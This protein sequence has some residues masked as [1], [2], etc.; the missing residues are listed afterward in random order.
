METFFT[1]TD[2]QSQEITDCAART[3]GWLRGGSPVV[4]CDLCPGNGTRYF[5][6]LTAMENSVPNPEPMVSG[7]YVLSLPFFQTSYFTSL[8]GHTS[9]DYAAQKWTRGNIADGEVVSAFINEVARL[10]R[11]YRQYR[12]S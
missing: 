6:V 5:I 1:L 11:Q 9:P 12:E 4:T 8:P 7:D 3:A 10:L 2:L